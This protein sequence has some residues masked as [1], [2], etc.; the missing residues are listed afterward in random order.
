MNGVKY[1]GTSGKEPAQTPQN[2]KSNRRALRILQCSR[3]SA[4]NRQAVP[5][6]PTNTSKLQCERL[7]PTS[8]TGRPNEYLKAPVRVPQNPK[9]YRKAQRI[10]QSL[11]ASA[12]NRQVVPVGHTNTSKLPCE[13]LKPTSRTGRLNEY[14]KAPS[15]SASNPQVVPEGHTNTSK[16][17]CERLKPASRIGRPNEYLKAPSASASNPQVA[18]AG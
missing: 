15:A 14:P 18:T 7:K 5:A 6:G 3:A 9:S 4:S 2:F 16:L 10:P 1:F 11:R 8:R 17:P 12:S 13:C